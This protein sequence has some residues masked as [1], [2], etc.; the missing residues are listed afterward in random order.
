MDRTRG[1]EQQ[2]VE[3]AK[4]KQRELDDAHGKELQ[5]KVRAMDLQKA[6]ALKELQDSMQQQIQVRTTR[7]PRTARANDQRSEGRTADSTRHPRC[8]MSVRLSWLC[9][10]N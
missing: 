10:L 8:R 6:A 3:G 1:M 7:T 5:H 4:A 9:R 2:L